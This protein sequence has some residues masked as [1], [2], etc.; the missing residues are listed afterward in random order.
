M[1]GMSSKMGKV[2]LMCGRVRENIP[3]NNRITCHALFS[4][5]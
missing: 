5:D 3:R 2:V 1:I 4:F